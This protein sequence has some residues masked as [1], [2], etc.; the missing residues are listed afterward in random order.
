MN[1]NQ[2]MTEVSDRSLRPEFK[3]YYRQVFKRMTP[4]EKSGFL[5]HD[6]NTLLTPIASGIDVVLLT[7]ESPFQAEIKQETKFIRNRLRNPNLIG[8]NDYLRSI[9]KLIQLTGEIEGDDDLIKDYIKTIPTSRKIVASYISIIRFLKHPSDV[10]WNYTQKIGATAK[11]IFNNSNLSSNPELD[12][13]N[14]HIVMF[15]NAFIK[16]RSYC[17]DLNIVFDSNGGITITGKPKTALEEL[18]PQIFE[19]Y[20]K[21]QSERDIPSKEDLLGNNS[22][23]FS[24]GLFMSEL[25]ALACG[26]NMSIQYQGEQVILTIK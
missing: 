6:F 13:D 2:S 18:R 7:Q 4:Y 15:H 9:D 11:E 16:L 23:V 22:A 5:S 24:S 20:T 10:L 26:Q 12:L 3:N 17:D 14:A 8:L 21:P 19:R 1:E 25:L